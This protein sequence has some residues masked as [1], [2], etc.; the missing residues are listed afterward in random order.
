MDYFRSSATDDHHL[1]DL[2]ADSRQAGID[3]PAW[4][5]TVLTKNRDQQS[6]AFGAAAKLDLPCRL[7][8]ILP[9]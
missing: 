7:D 4:E 1:V 9:G 8:L 3:D 6:P 2:S 5:V